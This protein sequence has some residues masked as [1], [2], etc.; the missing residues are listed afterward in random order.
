MFM[1]RASLFQY[2]W[3]I[4]CFLV[5]YYTYIFYL[6]TIVYRLDLYYTIPIL[7]YSFNRVGRKRLQIETRDFFKTVRGWRWR[8]SLLWFMPRCIPGLNPVQH[9]DVF[10][11]GVHFTSMGTLIVTT[12]DIRALKTI[13]CNIIRWNK[14]C[15]HG[16]F[17]SLR[18][19]LCRSVN[20]ELGNGTFFSTY[21]SNLYTFMAHP[22]YYH[23]YFELDITCTFYFVCWHFFSISGYTR[24]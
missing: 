16:F 19:L 22:V 20:N 18:S 4:N 10:T 23:Y 8:W 14:M 17:Q 6:L 15:I 12:A 5:K 21:V 2:T 11:E 9:R 1:V 24:I 3:Y 13:W 7:L